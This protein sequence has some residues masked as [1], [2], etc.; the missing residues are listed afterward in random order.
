MR[1]RFAPQLISGPR[2]AMLGRLVGIGVAQAV[3][4]LSSA[5]LVHAFFDHAVQGRDVASAATG[6]IAALIASGGALAWFKTVERIQA[7]RMGQHYAA[8]LR[9]ALFDGLAA[10]SPRRL[11]SRS[12]GGTLLRFMGDVKGVRRWVSLG[13][14]RLAVGALSAVIA[15]L[16][17][18]VVDPWL[19]V[20]A[21]SGFALSGIALAW[22][23]MRVEPA[24]RESRRRQARLA[25]DVN[26]RIAAIAVVQV[27]DQVEREKRRLG[28]QSEA[29]ANAMVDQMRGVSL[30]RSA[31]EFGGALASALVL[32]A[33]AVEVGRGMLE[34]ADVVGALTVVGLIAPAF[35]DL[36]QV[37]GY[38]RT[39]TVSLDKIDEFLAAPRLSTRSE[40]EESPRLPRRGR[41]VSVSFRDVSVGEALQGFTAHARAGRKI[42]IVGPNGSGKSTV[43]GL[44]ARM[45]DADQG[46]VRVAGHAVQEYPLSR[47]RARLGVVT[48]DLPLLRGSIERNLV[49]RKPRAGHDERSR[50]ESMC[51]VDELLQTLPRGG[52]TRVAEGG[53]NL[54]YGQRQRIAWARALLGQPGLLLLDEADANLDPA[55]ASRLGEVLADYAGT[56][57][58]VTH[59]LARVMQADEVWFLDGGRLVEKGAPQELMGRVSR[60]RQLFRAEART[61]QGEC[62]A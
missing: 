50:V 45:L 48:P 23:T 37:L 29:L 59:H 17:L 27:F 24:V 20:S 61:T 7:E 11:Q 30:L 8:E 9:L 32:F 46:E 55:S 33:G 51:G 2:R 31:A 28:R 40:G 62:A 54:S 21:V 12:R 52:L 14:P 38:W 19:T 53:G 18:A 56:V 44:V 3:L 26:D 5:W 42:A 49:Y 34:A 43:L 13:L 58:M 39:A 15:L 25:A 47:L 16:A 35:R 57:L 60:T 41:A 22:L 36:G 4:T 1:T 6:L 10:Q